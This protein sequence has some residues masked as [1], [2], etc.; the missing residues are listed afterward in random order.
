MNLPIKILLKRTR[1]LE[2]GHT[3]NIVIKYKNYRINEPDQF[4]ENLQINFFAIMDAGNNLYHFNRL[5]AKHLAK[6]NLNELLQIPSIRKIEIHE[7]TSEGEK[8]LRTMNLDDFKTE[9]RGKIQLLKKLIKEFPR[10]EVGIVKGA[11]VELEKYL[12]E[13]M[14]DYIDSKD[15]PV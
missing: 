4:L 10:A 7:L 14:S 3:Y 12:I 9:D 13:Y 6:T 11:I 2:S 8:R 15:L 1:V 5:E